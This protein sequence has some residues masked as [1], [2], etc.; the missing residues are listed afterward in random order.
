MVA[1]LQKIHIAMHGLP[2]RP[3]KDKNVSF[4]IC[5]GVQ[6]A[7]AASSRGLV[8]NDPL[9]RKRF[10]AVLGTRHPDPAKRFSL[11]PWN[12]C[13]PEDIHSAGCIRGNC[14]SAIKAVS[15]V[16]QISIRLEGSSLAIE[17]RK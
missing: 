9:N 12:G 3:E 16:N 14:A 15:K 2:G 1:R 5:P 7:T 10:S 13:V 4:L 6:R 17:P 11:L 8:E